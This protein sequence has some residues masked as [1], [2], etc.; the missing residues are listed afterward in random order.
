MPT[1]AITQLD[2]VPFTAFICRR[3]TSQSSVAN[4]KIK[5]TFKGKCGSYIRIGIDGP[6]VLT[7][8]VEHIYCGE[9]CEDC[10]NAIT[11]AKKVI[12]SGR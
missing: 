9:D 8:E 11:L 12:E 10:K 1:K 4:P 6:Q 5:R 3:Y 7:V 2:P